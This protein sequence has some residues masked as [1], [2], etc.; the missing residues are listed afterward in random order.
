MLS[1][2]TYYAWFSTTCQ[3]VF[4]FFCLSL[5]FV[6]CCYFGIAAALPNSFVFR[7]KTVPLTFCNHILAKWQL[8]HLVYLRSIY[9]RTR[10]EFS[11]VNAR[12]R[13]EIETSCEMKISKRAESE[14]VS[15]STQLG[16]MAFFI[17][18]FTSLRTLLIL[19]FY[20]SS[21]ETGKIVIS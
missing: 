9:G 14:C 18:Q 4:F 1:Q 17:C 6:Y 12:S 3:Q 13:V 8:H 10:L 7:Y 2:A 19:V 5:F 21:Q 11:L 15:L 20:I 16:R